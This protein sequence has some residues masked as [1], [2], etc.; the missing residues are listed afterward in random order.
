MHTENNPSVGKPTTASASLDR[1]KNDVTEVMDK[2]KTAGR[3]E[4][5][6]GK[7]AAASQAE[8]VAGVIEQVSSQLKECNLDTLADY[9]NELAP[10]IKNFLCRI[11]KMN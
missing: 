2:A 1:I 9:R 8:R 4:L 5:E 3:E 11:A 7:Q 10:G 6:S